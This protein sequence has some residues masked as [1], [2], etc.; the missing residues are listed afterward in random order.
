MKP[1]NRKSYGSIPHLPGSKLGPGDHHVHEG[2]AVIA[3][4]KPRDKHDLIIVQEKIDGSNVGV[5]KV[6]G[7]IHAI[8]RSGYLASSSPH[9]QHHLFSLWVDDKK[10][11]FD[12]LLDEG[13]RVC[14]EWIAMAHG[15]R[16]KYDQPFIPFDIFDKS[17]R[18]LT[19]DEM[20]GRIFGSTNLTPARLVQMPGAPISTDSAYSLLFKYG[21]HGALDPV[22]G[23][24]YRVERKGEVDF[25]C[26]WV[27]EDYEPGRYFEEKTGKTIWNDVGI[28]AELYARLGIKL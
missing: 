9:L 18:R 24:I 25:L 23:I 20:Q 27:R 21:Y 8:G 22:E 3:T 2:Q 10:A 16:Y 17:N 14:G 6:D 19:L 26:K 13:E 4:I 12:A 15:T 1:L 7:V 11:E 28:H 5:C